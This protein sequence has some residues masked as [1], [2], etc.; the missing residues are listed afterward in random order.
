MG[1]VHTRRGSW[2]T[3]GAVVGLSGLAVALLLTFVS[4]GG[5]DA[6]DGAGGSG[7]AHEVAAGFAAA[8]AE[9]DTGR[10][11]ELTCPSARDDVMDDVAN[12]IDDITAADLGATLSTSGRKAS[13][14]VSITVHQHYVV[15]APSGGVQSEEATPTVTGH[16]GMTREQDGWC[17]SDLDVALPTY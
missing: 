13:A 15:P 12:L 10:V 7:S 1:R 9:H 16:L 14:T 8:L 6:G 17:V 3:L 5:T 4:D 2:L 11:R